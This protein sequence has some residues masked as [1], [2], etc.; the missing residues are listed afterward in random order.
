[1]AGECAPLSVR[2]AGARPARRPIRASSSGPPRPLLLA[3]EARHNL[4][5]GLAATL[6]DHPQL[7]PEH[8]LWLVE[9]GR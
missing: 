5:L 2:S 9:D 3:D 1:M 8:R 7:Y 4:I 6:R